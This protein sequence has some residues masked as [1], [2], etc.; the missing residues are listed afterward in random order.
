MGP[1]KVTQHFKPPKDHLDPVHTQHHIRGQSLT[2]KLNPDH[3]TSIVAPHSGARLSWFQSLLRQASG[4]LVSPGCI[5]P[6]A[7]WAIQHE[8][9]GGG[10]GGDQLHR[11]EAA[12]QAGVVLLQQG[13]AAPG[14]W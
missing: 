13:A 1:L 5:T 14:R 9:G 7:T 3:V 2:K 8:D 10:G 12:G 4:G 11:V 6:G